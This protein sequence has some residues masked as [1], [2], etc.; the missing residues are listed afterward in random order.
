[1]IREKGTISGKLL[2]VDFFAVNRGGKRVPER[3]PKS[4]TSSEEQ[5]KYNYERATKRLVRL[6]NTNFD[7]RDYWCTI[8]LKAE[9]APKTEEEFDKLIVNYFRRVNYYRQAHGLENCLYAY[10]REFAT[11][12]T[13]PKKGQP[14]LHLHFWIQGRGMSRD[15]IK[16][17][18]KNGHMSCDEFD[19]RTFGPEAACRYVRKNPTGKKKFVTSK[20]MVQPEDLGPIDGETSRSDLEQ[21]AKL[22]IDDK[23]FWEVFIL[24]LVKE[25]YKKMIEKE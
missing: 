17:L 10:I 24:D 23:A 4:K 14:N 3:Q 8:T 11:Y 25:A 6:I 22:H 20:N 21:M 1:M 18:W 15:E 19:P 9:E 2:D 7:E 13:G 12:K 5:E 16:A